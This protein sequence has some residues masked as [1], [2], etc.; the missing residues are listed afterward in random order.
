MRQLTINILTIL[1]L[2]LP[3]TT[4]SQE[5]NTELADKYFNSG[6]YQSALTKYQKAFKKNRI[7]HKKDKYEYFHLL[8]QISE[9]KRLLNDSTCKSDYQNI[10]DKHSRIERPDNLKLDKRV[11]LFIAESEKNLKNFSSAERYYKQAFRNIDT[12]PDFFKLGYAFCSL[13]QN[14]FGQALMLLKEIKDSGKLEPQFSQYA[15]I[16]KMELSKSIAKNIGINDTLHLTMNY[17]GCFGGT[18]YKFAIIKHLSDYQV[19]SYKGQRLYENKSWKIDS[20]QTISDSMYLKVIAFENELRNYNQYT[21]TMSCTVWA[22]FLIAT[23]NDFYR[24]EIT[25]CALGIGYGIEKLLNKK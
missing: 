5:K 11:S 15:S 18:S 21:S 10:V 23:K 14:R 17:R 4:Y 22:D 19:I 8:F 2:L 1:G 24:I 3:R 25:D 9:S 20:I 7:W 6:Q 12:I 13:K 16:C